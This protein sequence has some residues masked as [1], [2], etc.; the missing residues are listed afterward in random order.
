ML[1]R[2]VRSRS[3]RPDY[4]QDHLLIPTVFVHLAGVEV[5]FEYPTPVGQEL[6]STWNA[7]LTRC[8]ISA[9]RCLRRCC[10]TF[11]LRLVSRH[12]RDRDTNIGHNDSRLVRRRQHVVEL[13]PIAVHE[14]VAVDVV[15]A[16]VHGRNRTRRRNVRSRQYSCCNECLVVT[17]YPR[18]RPVRQPICRRH[19]KRR[20]RVH[21]AIW[22]YRVR[23]PLTILD[24]AHDE[25]Y[26]EQCRHDR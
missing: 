2:E 4:G 13:E 5:S 17:Q 11:L 12:V 1:D 10:A 20:S 16:I 22:W 3:I 7:T 9:C 19:R 23:C 8:S 15:T 6:R 21:G 24:E 18:V 14:A 25:H 26:S